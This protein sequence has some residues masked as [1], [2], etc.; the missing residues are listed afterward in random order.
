MARADSVKS[1]RLR[2]QVGPLE[3]ELY[4]R[5]RTCFVRPQYSHDPLGE[6]TRPLISISLAKYLER[7][8]QRNPLNARGRAS[9]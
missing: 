2:F 6:V 4:L 5:I 3:I 8:E 1:D 9:G 7:R